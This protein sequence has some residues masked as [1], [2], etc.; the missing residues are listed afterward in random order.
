M[1]PADIMLRFQAATTFASVAVYLAFGPGDGLAL[2][3]TP[4][5]SAF[6][7]T[8]VSA[9]PTTKV[10]TRPRR[11]LV[12]AAGATGGK[13]RKRRKKEPN[14]SV[15]SKSSSPS[16]A[17]VPGV[18]QDDDFVAGKDGEEPEYQSARDL[19][20]VLD[21]EKELEELFTDDW[22]DMPANNGMV[23]TKVS[24][25]LPLGRLVVRSLQ[26]RRRGKNVGKRA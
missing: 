26:A 3:S 11:T 6:Y 10:C 22:S 21:R 20:E 25:D 14:P 19:A 9:S 24:L 12:M 16:G 1:K 4:L 17:L 7:T 15:R 23:K 8:H 2:R 18:L 13:K 5:P